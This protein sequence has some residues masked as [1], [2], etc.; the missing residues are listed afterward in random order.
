VGL[1][2]GSDRWDAR[3]LARS[4]GIRVESLG[5]HSPPISREALL[6]APFL[7]P[8]PVGEK[9]FLAPRELGRIGVRCTPSQ[10]PLTAI[11]ALEVGS[12]AAAL[13]RVWGADAEALVEP[14]I[15]DTPDRFRP[16]F[17]AAL[18]LGA[19]PGRAAGI[20]RLCRDLP[21]YRCVH[22]TTRWAEDVVRECAALL[23]KGR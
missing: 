10:V 9:A 15:D 19:V 2:A 5:D 6:G 7:H 17:A 12:D 22:P 14:W 8:R 11:V 16:H 3:G 23:A 13:T 4:T 20:R 18:G 21:V 1:K